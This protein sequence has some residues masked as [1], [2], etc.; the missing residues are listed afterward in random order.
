MMTALIVD[1]EPLAREGVRMLLLDSTNAGRE[2]TT[3]SERRVGEAFART[4]SA[5]DRRVFVTT[6]SSHV[7]R[8]QQ[9]IDGAVRAGRKVA[10]VGRRMTSSLGTA[11]ETSRLHVPPLAIV[12]PEE[13]MELP[14]ERCLF[15]AGGSQGEPG[16]AMSRIS[17]G[18]HPEAR[19]E[20][21]DVVVYSAR[22]I[23]GNEIAIGRMLDDLARRGAELIAGEGSGLHVSGHA[24]REDLSALINAS[25]PEILVPIHGTYRHLLECA[26]L[27]E[28]VPRPPSAILLAENGDII[29][30]DGS[31]ARVQGRMDVRPILIDRE[32]DR[33]EEEVLH[34]RRQLAADGI[35]LLLIVVDR[36]TGR[37][38][39]RPEVLAR[40]FAAPGGEEE[41][42]RE[43]A[44]LAEET[45]RADGSSEATEASLGESLA[46]VV[47]RFVR[48]RTGKTPM[49]TPIVVEI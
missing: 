2:G 17:R 35:L 26:R 36:S 12:R 8:V 32:H 11:R 40:G 6:F 42:L 9:F 21:G 44:R 48:R 46:L 49:V 20:R 16:S 3:S 15:I 31:G 29:R 19:I 24:S 33:V 14:P 7:H 27:A 39:S 30:L 25:Q 34:E 28:S 18:L 13:A 5:I 47:R 45:A 37:L 22:P 10:I 1:D 43:A 41:L 38:L 23:P 4:L